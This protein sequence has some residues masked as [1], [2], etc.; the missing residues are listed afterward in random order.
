[1]SIPPSELVPPRKVANGRAVPVE[2]SSAMTASEPPPL[3][4][5]SGAP[6]L[7]GKST[8]EVLPVNQALPAVSRTI[9][10]NASKPDPPTNVEKN[11]AD[12]AALN[13]VTNASL[14][15]LPLSNA[16]AVVGQSN[17]GVEPLT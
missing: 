2:F 4:V 11:N 5:V 9:A 3:N 13:L 1:M 10:P 7:T 12:P 8:D 6:A 17:E 15:L 16:P 14:L